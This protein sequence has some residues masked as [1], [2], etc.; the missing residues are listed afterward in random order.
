MT[1]VV[2]CSL[3]GS[4]QMFALKQLQTNWCWM[5]KFAQLGINSIACAR[6][7]FKSKHPNNK[8]TILLTF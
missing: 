1:S 5:V 7:F 6:R 4:V 3:F 8:L 2:F